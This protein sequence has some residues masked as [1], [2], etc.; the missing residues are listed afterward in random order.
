LTG[1]KCGVQIYLIWAFHFPPRPTNLCMQTILLQ[2]DA[3]LQ[4]FTRR[5][6]LFRRGGPLARNCGVLTRTGKPC[7]KPPLRGSNHCLRHGGPDAAR[8]FRE[9]QRA[10]L[11]TG[12]VT[13]KQWERAEAK[14]ASAAL[15]HAWLKN[16]KLSGKTIELN[17]NEEAFSA[18]A[19]ALGVDLTAL[20]PAVADWLRWRYQR[21]MI[22]RPDEVAWRSLV[23]DE[24]PRQIARAEAAIVWL[25]LGEG[26]RDRRTRPARALKALSKELS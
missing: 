22:D 11:R 10:A 18:S 5:T 7:G 17:K 23:R 20:Y 24:L 8:R 12:S 26:G 21:R 4:R 19:S 6:F 25:S 15:Q 16:P 9:L 13:P 1:L 2:S 14:R 3:D